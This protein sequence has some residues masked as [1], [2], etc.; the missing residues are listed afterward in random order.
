MYLIHLSCSNIA[1]IK[2]KNKKTPDLRG[3]LDGRHLLCEVKTI[4]VS[5][6][7]ADRRDRIHRG[8]IF[9]TSV[10]TNVTT[11]MLNKVSSTIVDAIE[12]LDHEDPGRT[13][14]RIVFTVLNFDDWVGDYQTQYIAQLDAHLAANPIEGAELVFCPASDLFEGR[15]T[16]RSAAVVKI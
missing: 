2:R 7:E 15:F 13:V 9:V 16:M 11:G 5:Q 12:Q 8:E 10:P 3:I 4:N 14:R 1:F 6:D